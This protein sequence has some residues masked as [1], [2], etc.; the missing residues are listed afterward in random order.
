MLL[1]IA[2]CRD[3]KTAKVP[4]PPDQIRCITEFPVLKLLFGHKLRLISAK[5]EDPSDPLL[6]QLG[7]TLRKSLLRHPHC[8]HMGQCLYIAQILDVG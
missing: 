2:G 1:G 8:R 7:Q 3:L 5:G 6:L 4:D